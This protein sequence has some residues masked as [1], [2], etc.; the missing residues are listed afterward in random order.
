MGFDTLDIQQFKNDFEKTQGIAN[1]NIDAFSV[2]VKAV[3]NSQNLINSF[4]EVNDQDE[5]E[6]VENAYIKGKFFPKNVK[7]LKPGDWIILKGRPVKLIECPQ[8]NYSMSGP[9]EKIKLL[10][11]KLCNELRFKDD[12]LNGNIKTLYGNIA[13]D[14]IL[15]FQPGLFRIGFTLHIKQDEIEKMFFFEELKEKYSAILSKYM[16]A[17][18][19]GNVDISDTCIGATINMETINSIDD[20]NTIIKNIKN[21]MDNAGDVILLNS[22]TIADDQLKNTRYDKIELEN[23]GSFTLQFS[24]ERPAWYIGKIYWEG[25]K[26]G[27]FI[28]VQIQYDEPKKMAG[29]IKTL[30]K[31]KKEEKKWDKKLKK[32][33][34]GNLFKNKIDGEKYLEQA[35]LDSINILKK[36]KFSVYLSNGGMADCKKVCVMC[37]PIWGIRRIE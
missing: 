26:T 13:E 24:E 32:Y 27:K 8:N 2:T 31:I 20:I 5:I 22:K 16:S 4:T 29:K 6:L 18:F 37:N 25:A 1:Q 28:D 21:I 7:D 10:C 11:D 33:A 30:Y 14:L 17:Y 36:N 34:A 35:E 12:I 23:F 15:F 9:D 19:L 3:N